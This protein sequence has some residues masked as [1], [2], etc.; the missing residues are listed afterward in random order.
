MHE[1]ALAESVIKSSIAAAEKEKLVKITE[2]N[3]LLG[4]LQQIADDI[5]RFALDELVVL[6]KD[7]FQNV[8]I[9]IET[10]KTLLQCKQCEHSWEFG[11]MKEKLN[12]DEAEAI[13]FIPEVAFVHTRCPQCGSP[14]FE[15]LKGRGVSV[16]SIKGVKE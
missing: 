9:N 7:S 1:W 6:Y 10:E 15:I 3:V 13:H 5:F 14:D 16:S 2:I 4:E 12:P 8:T 11:D